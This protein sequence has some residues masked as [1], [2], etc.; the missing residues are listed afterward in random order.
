MSEKV[1]RPEPLSILK[2]GLLRNRVY[3]VT[4]FLYEFYGVTRTT[5]GNMDPEYDKVA[6]S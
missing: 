4:V 5:S 6:A 2:R 3:K 1:V